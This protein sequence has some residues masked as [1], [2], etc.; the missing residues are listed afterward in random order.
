MRGVLRAVLGR[1]ICLPSDVLQ[2]FPALAEANWRAGGLPPRLG[3]ALLG[4]HSAAGIT[5]W[6][7]VFLGDGVDPTPELLLHELAHVRQFAARWDFPLRYL[8]ECVRCGYH[9]NRFEQDAR[10]FA[11]AELRPGRAQSP[12]PLTDV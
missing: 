3:G 7:T 4:Q 12:Y 5:L 2:R 6:R 1:P 11:E 9:G 10:A 8:W